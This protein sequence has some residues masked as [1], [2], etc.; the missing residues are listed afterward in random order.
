MFKLSIAV[1][2]RMISSRRITAG[3]IE[4]ALIIGRPCTEVTQIDLMRHVAV[5]LQYFGGLPY[6]DTV[7]SATEKM[8]LPRLSYQECAD[9]ACHNLVDTQII[10]TRGLFANSCVIP[11]NRKQIRCHTSNTYNYN[12]EYAKKAAEAFGELLTLVESGQTQYALA[13]FDYSDSFCSTRHFPVLTSSIEYFRITIRSRCRFGMIINIT[14]SNW[15]MTKL[16]GPK[17]Y[18]LV[19]HDNI[20]H[21]PTANYVNLYGMENGLPL[22]EDSP[23]FVCQQLCYPN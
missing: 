23:R 4:P 11:I 8:S 6:I 7:L 2:V 21:Q 20:I 22:S 12:T 5:T 19:E 17:I 18:G 14:I 15:N 13:Q 16:W 1:T 10:L 9:K 3:T